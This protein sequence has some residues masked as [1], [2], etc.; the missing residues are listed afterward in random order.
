MA[1][2][3]LRKRTLKHL[4]VAAI[5]P[6]TKKAI[7]QGGVKVDVVPKEY[8]AESV[9]RSLR[10][11]SQREAGVAGASQGCPRRDSAG[12][13][14]GGS[15]G[16]CR[17]GLRNC[18]A[19]NFARSMRAALKNPRRRPHVVTFTSSSTVRNFVA[20]L[21]GSRSERAKLNSYGFHWARYF[22]N[23][24]GVGAAGGYRG[25]GVHHSGAG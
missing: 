21:G 14:Q 8:V 6:A 22:F 16:R 23:V 13:A 7:E 20:L 19:A 4:R 3:R 15:P 18:G 2:L 11:R 10:R 9:V 1:T 12:A 24:A 5:G 17:G 25:C